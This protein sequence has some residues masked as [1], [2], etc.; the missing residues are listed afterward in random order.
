MATAPEIDV[1]DALNIRI[2]SLVTGINLFD[3]K[4]REAGPYIPDAAT[5]VQITE[6]GA[7]QPFAGGTTY[8]E[9]ASVVKIMV[10]SAPDDFDSSRTLMR[11]IQAALDKIDLTGYI[12]VR[13]LQSDPYD[14]GED[15][16]R[17]HYWEINIE[18]LHDR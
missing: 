9:H 4:M 10:R 2:G 12:E 6:G 13:A 5:F 16:K 1:R 17:R 11:S 14:I 7:P 18:L 15:T 3:G 8:Q